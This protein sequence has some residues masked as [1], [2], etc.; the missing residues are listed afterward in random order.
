MRGHLAMLDPEIVFTFT[1][2]LRTRLDLAI[3]ASGHGVSRREARRLLAGRRVLVNGKP[4]ANASRSVSEREAVTVARAESLPLSFLR[5]ESDWVAVDKQPGVPT[6]PTRERN[7]VSLADL[8]ALELQSEVF[9]VHRLDAGT[10]GVLLLALTQV[11]AARLSKLFA[12]GEMKKEYLALVTGRVDAP[13]V[14]D[15][16]IARESADRFEVQ[17]GGV[18]ATTRATPVAA[19]DAA[20]LLSIEIV[21]GRTHQIRVHLSSA[22]HAVLGDRKYGRGGDHPRPMLHAW[23]LTHDA[24]G[25]IESPIPS[26]FMDATTALGLELGAGASRPHD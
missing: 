23:R 24:L 19:T 16:P 3:A 10:S 22:G 18:S 26:D 21:S 13:L 20:S 25:T 5:R 1:P 12:S 6:Q 2:L 9:V 8:V 15:A 11:A 14:T 17:E 4:V 7:A